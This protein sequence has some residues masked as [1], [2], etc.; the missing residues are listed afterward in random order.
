MIALLMAIAS[1]SRMEAQQTQLRAEVVSRIEDLL[2]VFRKGDSRA[3]AQI[4]RD[5]ASIIGPGVRVT[6]R[7]AIDSYWVARPRPTSWDIETLDVG[8]S[9]DE[10]WHYARSIRVN[11][12]GARSDTT[13]T[14]FILIWKRGSDGKL[15]IY[16]DL[17]T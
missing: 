17:Y 16:L 13:I 12:S 1:S 7:A 11:R 10:P 6:G 15:R 4:F 3:V 2:A 5:D 14:T 9:R 8:G